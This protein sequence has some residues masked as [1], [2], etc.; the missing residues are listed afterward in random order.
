MLQP[1][2]GCCDHSNDPAASL[3]GREFPD[4]LRTNIN[5][6]SKILYHKVSGGCK[7]DLEFC[8]ELNII[9]GDSITSF[10]LA[11]WVEVSC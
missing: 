6:P 7:Y 11:V 5:L 4:S 3:N 8:A 9:Y 1:I 2:S 10:T